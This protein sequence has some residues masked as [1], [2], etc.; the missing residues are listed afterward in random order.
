M[1]PIGARTEFSTAGVHRD[2]NRSGMSDNVPAA[3]A[4]SRFLPVLAGLFAIVIFVIDTV[5]PLDIAIAVLYVVVV[6]IA[7]NIYQRR[8]LLVAAAAC[9]ALTLLSYFIVHEPE[10]DSALVRCLMSL[11]AIGAT[12]FLALRNQAANAMLRERSRLLDLTH[13]TIF[14]RNMNDTITYW[15]LGAEK[16]YGWR[17]DEA[18]GKN[19]HQLMKTVFPVPLESI[20]AELAR[21]GRWEGELL[22]TK[23]DG[24]SVKVASRWSLQTDERN[25]LIGTLETNNDIPEHSRAQEAPQAA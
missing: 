23:R 9:M 4:R 7:S 5:V 11:A 3:P 6:L 19:S 15:N 22:H 12:T 2:P 8:G 16:L 10:A 24:T 14:A 17:A 25:R 18:I 21:T 20:Y 13:D 1:K